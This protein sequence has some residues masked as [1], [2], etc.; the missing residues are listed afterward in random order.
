MHGPARPGRALTDGF[1]SMGT[2][3]ALV[4]VISAFAVVMA[5]FGLHWIALVIGFFALFVAAVKV[6]RPGY[7]LTAATLMAV[8][9]PVDDAF[10]MSRADL[11]LITK[12]AE[13]GDAFSS[14]V[15]SI[16]E[17]TTNVSGPL[18]VATLVLV[19]IAIWIAA[20]RAS[21]DGW[22]FYLRESDALGEMTVRIGKAAS[23]LYVPMIFIIV[24]D[25]SQRKMLEFWPTF[26][27]TG[28]YHTFTSTKLQEAEW[29]LHAVLFLLCFGYAYIKDAH[30]RIELV[31]DKLAPRTRVWI[32]L[33]GCIFFLVAYCYVVIRFGYDFAQNS[34]KLLEQSSAQ[35]GLPLRFIIK[36]FLPLGFLILGLAGVAVAVKCV[37]YLFGPEALRSASG[38]YA[39][40]HH[41]DIPE[42]AVEPIAAE[43]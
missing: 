28:W 40:T 27:E 34:F 32:E 14:A 43:R 22:S 37:V 26:A 7:F 31:R 33:L 12:A 13:D 19:A 20:R 30:V 21:P 1:G 3:S 10:E 35:T 9:V 39:G 18:V 15:L 25:V 23:F 16:H 11:R 2:L 38:Y 42:D 6:T 8:S 17:V 24:Y 4:A 41:A 5:P 29:H 36:S